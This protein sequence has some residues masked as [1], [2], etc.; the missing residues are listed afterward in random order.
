MNLFGDNCYA[1]GSDLDNS[2]VVGLEECDSDD[3]DDDPTHPVLL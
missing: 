3:E 2:D 1:P